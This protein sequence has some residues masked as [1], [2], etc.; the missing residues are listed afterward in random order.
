MTCAWSAAI[1][2]WVRRLPPKK[3]ALAV[4]SQTPT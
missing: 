2:F 1:G 4:K 3:F